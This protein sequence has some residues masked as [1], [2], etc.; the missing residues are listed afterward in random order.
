ML[1][2]DLDLIYV[3]SETE[4]LMIEG[5]AE[6]ISDERFYEALEYGQK[7]IQ[8]I[9]AAQHKLA[10]LAGKKKDFAGG[11]D[12]EIVDFYEEHAAA[13]VKDALAFDS[14]S[15]RSWQSNLS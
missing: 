8:P 14:Y 11:D 7:A 12:S 9:I 4:M 5:S 3:G 10:E 1:D 13:K 15:E 2:S 6:F